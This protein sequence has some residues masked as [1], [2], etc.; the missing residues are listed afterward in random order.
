MENIMQ[1]V[2]DIRC[3]PLYHQITQEKFTI[4]IK[5]IMRIFSVLIR[6]TLNK[7]HCKII[8]DDAAVL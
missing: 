5:N 4:H 1:A 8:K 3:F 7:K 2:Y 6:F